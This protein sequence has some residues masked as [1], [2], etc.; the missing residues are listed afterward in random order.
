MVYAGPNKPV[1]PIS[2][3]YQMFGKLYGQ[4]KDRE[5]MSSVL[6]QVRDDLKKVRDL[7]SQEDRDL[8]DEQTTFVRELEKQLQADRSSE[9]VHE[10]PPLDPDVELDTRNM[11]QLSKMQIDLMVNSFANDYS[12]VATLQYTNS[13]GGARMK[14]LDIEE[15]HHELSHEP[16]S[17]EK[18]KEKLTKINHWYAEQMAY[19]AQRLAETPEP[20]GDGT[21]LDHTLIL[22]TNELG[23]GNSHT[24]DNIPFVLV[25][26][27]LD[28]RMGRSLQ[29]GGVP[30]NRL[31]MALAHGFGHHLDKFG[32]SNYC[33]AGPLY[34]G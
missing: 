23:K 7:V 6:D 21:L 19:M 33:G 34:L 22:W 31:L 8:L 28:F 14:W 24:Q 32:S 13:V 17:N 29:L 18:A 30:H 25:G 20:G 2:D 4:I 3:P 11:P 9:V 27:G 16:D 12:R 10:M 15:G 5:N 26:G 1:A